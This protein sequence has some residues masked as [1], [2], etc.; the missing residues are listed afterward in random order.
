MGLLGADDGPDDE[1][2]RLVAN[3]RGD[4]V[5]RERLT[6]KQEGVL[7][8]NLRDGSIVDYLADDEQPHFLLH[9]VSKGIVLE[10]PR[11]DQ[12]LRPKGTHRAFAVVTDRR[13]LFLTTTTS[14]GDAEVGVPYDAIEGFNLEQWRMVNHR[15]TLRGRQVGCRF[16]VNNNDLSEAELE[17]VRRYVAERITAAGDAY[18][19]EV[20]EVADAGTASAMLDAT[21][22]AEAAAD[23]MGEEPL[24]SG[25]GATMP[26]VDVYPERVVLASPNGSKSIDLDAITGVELEEASANESGYLYFDQRGYDRPD[27]GFAGT[28]YNV[29]EYNA[30]PGSANA[31]TFGVES[32]ER[33]QEIRRTVA[34]LVEN[35][36]N[37]EDDVAETDTEGERDADAEGEVQNA[38]TEADNAGAGNAENGCTDDESDD[39]GDTDDEAIRILREQ[40]AKGEISKEEYETRL[41]ILQDTS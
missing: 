27:R 13:V 4:S 21:R 17:A 20:Y 28:R 6:E 31:A 35:G 25:R 3:A 23:E 32:N 9:N 16:P 29:H 24:A 14:H 19:D 10:R 1:V 5:T 30:K 22:R 8:R 36:A 41:E 26:V 12:K 33:A 11:G 18:G 34:E 37:E 15:L 2:G 39:D 40:F 38:E 7:V